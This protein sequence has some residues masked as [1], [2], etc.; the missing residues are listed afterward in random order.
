MSASKPASEH[1]LAHRTGST[2]ARAGVLALGLV[3]AACRG[4]YS[5]S[6]T[7]CD[8]HC[9]I[10]ERADCSEDYPAD[11]VRDCEAARSGQACERAWQALDGCYAAAD[12]DAFVCVDDRSQPG[13]VCLPE[14]RGLSE[15]LLPGSGA[16]FDHCLRQ[17]EADEATLS[18]CEAGCHE[19][20]PGCEQ[21]S[22]DYYACLA[23]PPPSEEGPC[24]YEAL[25]LLACVK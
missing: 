12:A 16:C 25:G 21:I 9:K 10:I 4:D 24:Y 22:H 14:R 2:I 17:A 3:L 15:C 5:I 8:E 11:C 18:D 20:A 19:T 1:S 23:A 6:P 7:A 13:S